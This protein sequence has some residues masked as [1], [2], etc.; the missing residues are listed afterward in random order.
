M[1]CN[2]AELSV[3][4]RPD[5]DANALEETTGLPYVSKVRVHRDDATEAPLAKPMLKGDE[6]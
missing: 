3:I 5:M 1:L 2:G 4:Y 6:L